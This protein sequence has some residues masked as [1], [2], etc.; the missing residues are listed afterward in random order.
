MPLPVV[1][2]G[3][4]MV[5]ITCVEP[6][7]CCHLSCHGDSEDT[8][9]ATMV[10]SSLL[11]Q[12]VIEGGFVEWSWTFKGGSVVQP[13]TFESGLVEQLWT[14]EGWSVEQPWTFEGGFVVS[15]RQ[16]SGTYRSLI[17]R[18]II[19]LCL[20]R[21]CSRWRQGSDCTIKYIGLQDVH[22]TME[23]LSARGTKGEVIQ[24]AI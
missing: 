24:R 14:V 16:L 1:V 12:R 19:G 4:C 21:E 23:P 15:S 10:G 20:S 22:I 18:R 5:M 8:I 17:H 11:M 2:T 9:S 6:E 3:S 13:W 7:V